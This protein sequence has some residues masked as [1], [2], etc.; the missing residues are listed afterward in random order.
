MTR[1]I[2]LAL[3]LLAWLPTAH[4]QDA[5][6]PLEVPHGVSERQSYVD[7][8]RREAS[9]RGLPPE[10]AEAVAHVETGFRPDAV[11]AVGEIGL[12]QIRPATAEMLGHDGGALAL[13]DPETN[14]RFA[15]RYLAKAWKLAN[16]DLCRA[17]MKYRAGHGAETMS[18]LS[19]TY[20]LRAKAYLARLGSPL[21]DGVAPE[22]V[23]IREI[24]GD[25]PKTTTRKAGPYL[26]W[27]PGRHTASDNARF[28]ERHETRI[29]AL[30]A[31]IERR[32]KM[33]MAKR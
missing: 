22:V 31:K 25:Q 28:W 19:A 15:V 9:A 5:P 18:P 23:A 17:L 20:C 13:F 6:R 14:A 24:D 29:A 1:T 30:N 33:R 26:G 10:V 2:G 27:R 7:I 4:A 8:V 32:W 12:M 3:A 21:A 16:G 11:G